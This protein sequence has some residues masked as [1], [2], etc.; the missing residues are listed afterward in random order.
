MVTSVIMLQKKILKQFK[1]NINR[2]I[3][4]FY[5]LHFN[6]EKIKLSHVCT[7]KWKYISIV[8]YSNC[9]EIV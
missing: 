6:I 4:A 1:L 7:Q 9:S 2:I 3:K 5:K 8:N